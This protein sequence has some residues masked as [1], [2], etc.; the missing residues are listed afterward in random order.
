LLL[1]IRKAENR[2]EIGYELLPS[3]QG[4]G[5]MHEAISEVIEFGFQ[6]M[7]LQTIEAWSKIE[8]FNS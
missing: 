4:K 6:E 7:Q 1:N 5:I 2:A 3:F 8:N